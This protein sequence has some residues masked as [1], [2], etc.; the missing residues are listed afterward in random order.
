MRGVRVAAAG[1]M[2]LALL[3]TG[4]L[5]S[6]GG[7]R[8]IVGD[9]PV[10]PYRLY[11][12]TAPDP[13]HTG[14]V[15]YI[16]RLSDGASDEKIRGATVT[17]ELTNEETGE[18]LT[19]TATHMAEDA[20][21]YVAH[22]TVEDAGTWNGVLRIDGPAGPIE[23]RWTQEVVAERRASTLA[24]LGLPFLVILM[25]LGGFWVIR[26]RRATVAQA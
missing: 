14:I 20:I 3:S 12:I 25:G 2:L 21:D 17:V 22:V 8:V 7:T 5:A 9:E 18:V 6:D 19:R 23:S 10:G 15:S 13:A 16:A 11:F 24:A 1:L 26:S 4:V